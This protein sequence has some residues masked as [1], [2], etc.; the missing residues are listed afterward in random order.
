M[1]TI[2]NFTVYYL[3]WIYIKKT[4]QRFSMKFTENG[5]ILCA[6]AYINHQQKGKGHI[7]FKANTNILTVLNKCLM[8]HGKSFIAAVRSL[9]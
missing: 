1:K 8:T 5:L 4:L 3:V 6:Y 9:S 2:D 7:L